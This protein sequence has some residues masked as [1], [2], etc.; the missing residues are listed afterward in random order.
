MQRH[1]ISS[2]DDCK[3]PKFLILIVCHEGVEYVQQV[4]GQVCHTLRQ[5]HA[6]H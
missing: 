1:N 6:E 3:C 4:V 5:S 2:S